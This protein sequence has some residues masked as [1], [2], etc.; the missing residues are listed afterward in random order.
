MIVSA[1]PLTAM[2]QRR[3]PVRK[4]SGRAAGDRDDEVMQQ[5]P[6]TTAN[7]NRQQAPPA[8]LLSASRARSASGSALAED[9]SDDEPSVE[10]DD[11][12]NINKKI[13]SYRTT[14]KDADSA[15]SVINGGQPP[16]Q[17]RIDKG[18][19]NQMQQPKSTV[20]PAG[21]SNYRSAAKPHVHKATSGPS[22]SVLPW[23]LPL[24]LIPVLF[25]LTFTHPEKL[26]TQVTSNTYF[27]QSHQALQRLLSNVGVHTVDYQ[28][29]QQNLQSGQ[30]VNDW[31]DASPH[32][33]YSVATKLQPALL[34]RFDTA[35]QPSNVKHTTSSALPHT[36]ALH[37]PLVM[38]L[39]SKR[40]ATSAAA[41]QADTAAAS[42][43]VHALHDKLFN[44][45]SRLLEL[46][47]AAA[48]SG[49]DAN[50]KLS[51][52]LHSHF[53]VH[54]EGLVALQHLE[55]YDRHHAEQLQLFLDDSGDAPYKHA[56]YCLTLELPAT[57]WKTLQLDDTTNKHLLE[58]AGLEHL[59]KSVN[60]FTDKQYQ[61]QVA[62]VLQY[63]G[64][65]WKATDGG[66]DDT[67]QPLLIRI[68]KNVLIVT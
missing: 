64:Q 66:V 23:L 34:H 35:H 27:K 43:F 60:A 49:H 45:H 46:D 26:P 51:S 65:K 10:A 22:R 16:R 9:E 15:S 53:A 12:A 1:A 17:R 47:L 31:C 13:V 61:Q 36:T 39:V 30:W 50:A 14:V 11:D 28:R 37:S 2:D 62:A 59:T 5:R 3:Y 21:K 29:V 55:Q 19:P 57:E 44:V 6:K 58:H 25:Y 32:L 68:V 56:V 40:P 18:Q 42:N 48:A 24:L 7:T 33:C 52:E 63:L 54:D 41:R 38:L 8:P 20:Q 67:L 4:T